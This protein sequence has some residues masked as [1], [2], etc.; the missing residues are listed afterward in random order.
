MV[1]P[2]PHLGAANL[3][4]GRI[5]HEVVQGDTPHTPQPGLQVLHPNTDVV[6]QAGFCPVSLRHLHQSTSWLQLSIEREH[7]AG[8]SD[9]WTHHADK[10]CWKV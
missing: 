7:V 9:N 4:G 2:L 6:S 3:S 1:D 8:A 5:L 10:E